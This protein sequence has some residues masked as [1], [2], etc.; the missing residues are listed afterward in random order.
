[1]KGKALG[2]KALVELTSIVTPDTILRSHRELVAKKWDYSERR[3]KRSGR[4]PI[5]DD[6]K[7]LVVRMAKEHP[8]WGFDRIAGAV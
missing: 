3:Q 2:R 5:S 1:M 7:Q 4:P 8:T 6:V